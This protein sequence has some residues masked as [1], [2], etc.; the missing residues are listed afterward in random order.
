MESG[1]GAFNWTN[2]YTNVMPSNPKVVSNPLR[3]DTLTIQ[4]YGWAVIRFVADNPGLW[5]FHCH[6]AWHMEAGLL[7]QFMSRPDVLKTAVVPDDVK[8]LCPTN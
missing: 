3:R 8:A 6:I 2:Y 1:S 7:M 5:A 4:A